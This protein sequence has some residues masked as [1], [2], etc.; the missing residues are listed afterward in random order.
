LIWKLEIPL[1][2]TTLFPR[3]RSDW[4]GFLLDGG[5]QSLSYPTERNKRYDTNLSTKRIDVFLYLLLCDC[6]VWVSSQS[7]YAARLFLQGFR[8]FYSEST[9][10]YCSTKDKR[11]T[12]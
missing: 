11:A 12:R 2:K 5:L 10:C 1:P 6:S 7:L 4:F 8:G 3:Q 9:W